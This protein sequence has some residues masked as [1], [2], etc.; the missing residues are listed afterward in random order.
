MNQQEDHLLESEKQT[1]SYEVIPENKELT[2]VEKTKENVK[3][4][5][6]EY[7]NR[8]SAISIEKKAN[9]KLKKLKKAVSDT[10]ETSFVFL[11][12]SAIMVVVTILASI[13]E[14][15]FLDESILSPFA[16]SASFFAAF[17][18]CF[19]YHRKKRRLLIYVKMVSEQKACSVQQLAKAAGVS[20]KVVSEQLK[21]FLLMDELDDLYFDEQAQ[22]LYL[23][24]EYQQKEIPQQVIPKSIETAPQKENPS[25]AKLQEFLQSLQTYQVCENSEKMQEQLNQIILSVE[26]LQRWLKAYPEDVRKIKR[27]SEYYLPTTEKLLQTYT[28]VSLHTD[29]SEAAIRVQTQI[30][31]SLQEV[32]KAFH[33]LMNHLI[34]RTELDISAEITAM[35]TILHQ[36]GLS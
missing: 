22:M 6:E 23:T 8:Y 18:G 13:D 24:K 36:D 34:E 2:L 31:N 14:E 19:F 28:Q 32:Q 29:T 21:N 15:T 4:A 25:C 11:V 10:K 27:F 26:K 3:K 7:K 20:P 9:Q 30:E 16:L 1:F 12:L 5:F 33:T 17:L 35:E